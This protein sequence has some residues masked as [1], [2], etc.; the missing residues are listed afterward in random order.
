MSHYVTCLY[1]KERF[2]RDKEPAEKI[3]RR[4]AH[5]E[6]F[7]KHEKEKTQEE[8]ELEDLK[9]YI[10]QVLDE[11]FIS[12]KVNRQIES[13]KKEYGYT[14]TGMLKTLIWWYEVKGNTIE[15]ANGGIGII[16]FIYK[17]AC[18]YYYSLYLARLANQDKDILNYKLKIKEVQIEPPVTKSKPPKLFN[19][20]D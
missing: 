8:R 7:E 1:C 11:P 19:L 13:F 15:K 3:G 10:M 6:C 20:D 4:Y 5:I 9:K 18:D 17:D 12:V 16:P 14:Y 2:D